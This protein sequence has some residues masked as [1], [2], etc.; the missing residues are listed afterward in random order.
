MAT[1]LAYPL[2]IVGTVIFAVAYPSWYS[3]SF[4]IS[5]VV[6]VT[7]SFVRN[8]GVDEEEMI[9]RLDKAMETKDSPSEMARWVP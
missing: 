9:K 4:S 3:I 8:R 5:A 7:I 6:I 1:F 2:T